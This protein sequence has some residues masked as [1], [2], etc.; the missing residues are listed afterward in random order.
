MKLLDDTGQEA[1]LEADRNPF[2]RI[3]LAHLKALQT[4]RDPEERRAWK[5]WDWKK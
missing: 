4:R 2:A 5:F 3:V 1:E